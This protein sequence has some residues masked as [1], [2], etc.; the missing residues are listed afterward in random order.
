[1]WRFPVWLQG[2]MGFIGALVVCLTLWWLHDRYV[3]FRV[4]RAFVA[5]ELQARDAK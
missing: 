2:A 1:M 3:E 5:H 4:M